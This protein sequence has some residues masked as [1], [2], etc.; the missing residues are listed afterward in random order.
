MIS[1]NLSWV[2]LLKKT[3]WKC[4]GVWKSW[5]GCVK[6]GDVELNEKKNTGMVREIVLDYKLRISRFVQQL[7]HR[8]ASKKIWNRNENGYRSVSILYIIQEPY[9]SV[10]LPATTFLMF[11]VFYHFLSIFLS[12][13]KPQKQSSDQIHLILR[14]KNKN[15]IR[16][17]C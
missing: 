2:I 10:V 6:S 8:M 7:D 1:F 13:K 9:R 14:Y 17:K 3:L 4:L 12:G 5:T 16:F 15:K 11:I